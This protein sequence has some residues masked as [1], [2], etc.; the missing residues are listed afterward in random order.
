MKL[1]FRILGAAVLV[2][3][4]TGPASATTINYTLTN[5]GNNT[6]RYDYVVTGWQPTEDFLCVYFPSL[7]PTNWSDYTELSASIPTGWWED[8][9]L[10]TEWSDWEFYVP[11]TTTSANFSLAFNYGGSLQLGDQ[12]FEIY[13]AQV[14]ELPVLVESGVT[15]DPPVLGGPPAAVPEPITLLLVGT[16]LIGVGFVARRRPQR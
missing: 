3:A 9:Y 11:P 8:P 16:S 15:T 4:L 7:F 5:L 14:G 10:S 1:I 13:S 12:Y 6:Y 2:L